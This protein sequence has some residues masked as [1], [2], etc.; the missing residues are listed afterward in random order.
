VD[1]GNA[2]KPGIEGLIRD[3]WA[4]S[5]TSSST[6]AAECDLGRPCR[7]HGDGH[8]VIDF[9]VCWILKLTRWPRHGR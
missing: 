3:F 4:S 8:R 6:A 1:L 7:D 5:Q 2:D 9:K